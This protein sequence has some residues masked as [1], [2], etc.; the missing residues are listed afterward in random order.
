MPRRHCAGWVADRRI[1]RR[2]GRRSIGIVQDGNRAGDVIARIRDLIKKAPP[3]KDRF[4]IN[5]AIREVIELTRGGSGE[6]RR[7]GA[8]GTRGRYCR[9]SKEI[10]SQL[11]QVILNL[12]INALEAMS[13]ASEGGARIA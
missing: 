4:E 6:E 5:E 13:G 12:I 2:C 11:Q 1:W 3:R 10:G 8:D 9:S 7:L